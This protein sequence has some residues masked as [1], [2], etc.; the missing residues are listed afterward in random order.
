M[1]APLM[2]GYMYMY[3][4]VNFGSASLPRL[5]RCNPRALVAPESN[6]KPPALMTSIVMSFV[7][8]YPS[9]SID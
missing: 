3:D 4:T 2:R 8:I 7:V 1:K 5:Y 6:N 9:Y